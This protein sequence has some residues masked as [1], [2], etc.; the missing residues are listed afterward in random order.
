LGDVEATPPTLPGLDRL[1]GLE[2][3]AVAPDEVRARVPV[4]PEILQPFGLVHGGVY[5]AIAESL[6]SVGTAAVVLEQGMTAMGMSNSTTFLRSIA[7]GTVHARAVPRHRGGTTW[8]W[9]VEITDDA[10]SV[11]AVSRVTIA[12][13]P[14]RTPMVAPPLP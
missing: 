3:I 7:A 4:R 12:V 8:V 13:R 2:L 1:L 9:D 14:A 11:C 5:A 10:G 6:A